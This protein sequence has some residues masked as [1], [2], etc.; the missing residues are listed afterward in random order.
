MKL[1][2]EKFGIRIAAAAAARSA[3]VALAFAVF[4]SALLGS[5]PAWS[6]SMSTSVLTFVAATTTTTT[7]GGDDVEL[8]IGLPQEHVGMSVEIELT[9]IGTALAGSDYTLV[10]ANPAQEIILGDGA[11]SPL[12]LSVESAPVE[13][14]LLLRPRVDD[15]ISQGDRFLN[16]RISRY[17][18]GLESTTT[19][20]TTT[21]TTT[22][23]STTTETTT[24]ET[25]TTETVSLPPALD[26]T[27]RDDE[28]PTV[29]QLQVGPNDDFAC[30]LLD[31]GS[32]RCGGDNTDGRATPPPDLGAVAQLGTGGEFAC[33]L[34][35]LGELR[36]WGNDV[37][38]RSL[39][40]EDALGPFIQLAVSRGHSCALAGSGQVHCWGGNGDGQ[41]K[42]TVGLGP[43]GTLGL[44]AQIGVG[45]EHSCA[46]TD[47]G[48]V[49]C[50]GKDGQSSPPDELGAVAQLGV[51]GSHNCALQRD[52]QVRCWGDNGS[53]RSTPPDDLGTVVQL[54][55]GRGHSCALTELG[56][57]RCWGA[58]ND[59][60]VSSQPNDLGPVA[61]VM[62]GRIHSC[63]RTVAGL[64]RCWGDSTEKFESL[65]MLPGSVTAID[66]S[67]LCALLADGSVYCPTKTEL[68]PPELSSSEVVMVILPQQLQ[69]GERAAIRFADL[70]ETAAAFTVRI[71]VFGEGTADVGSDYRL[72]DSNGRPVDAE[73][74]GSYL[75]GW[76][77]N[78]PQLAGNSLEAS[79]AG[80]GL[81]L[82][83]RPLESLLP[84]GS[85]SGSTPSI[86]VVAQSVELVELSDRLFF[87][88]STD[89]LSEGDEEA[90]FSIWL[91]PA[92]TGL[93]VELELLVGGTALAGSDYTLLA[94]DS[95]PGLMLGTGN[96]TI[97]LV[98]ESAFTPL[99]LRLRPRAADR[100]SQG[101]RLLNL[102]ISRYQVGLEITTT[103]TVSL[104]P[105]LDLTIVDDE[106]PTVQQLVF[107]GPFINFACILLNGGSVACE[108]IPFVPIVPRAM[109]PDDLGPVVQLGAG[110]SYACALTVFGEVRCWGGD[111]TLPADDLGP[112]T[113]L[114]VGDIHSCAVADSGQ[115]HCWGDNDDG[116]TTPTVGLG[117]GGALGPVVQLGVGDKHS[118]ALTDSGNV[119]CW[120]S[121]K[122][123]QSS[124]PDAQHPDGALGAVAQLG[125]GLS[126]NC[127]LLR[128]GQVRCWGRNA[129]GS[130]DSRARP[131]EDLGTV[132][133]LAVGNEHTCALTELGR[134]RCWGIDND[135]E[136]SPPDD[137]GP[138]AEIM[139]GRD[140]ACA[141]TVAGLLRCWGAPVDEFASLPPGLVTAID[142]SSLCALLADGSVYCPTKTELIPPELSPSEVVMSVWPQQL[143][144]GQRAAIR[145]ADLRETAAAFTVRIEVFGEGTADVGSYY[146][147]LDSNGQP[148]EAEPDA[149]SVLLT[150]NPPLAWLEATLAGS[151]SRLYVRPLN[152][153]MPLGL[154]PSVR[155]AAQPVDLVELSDRPFFAA[156]T[157]TLSEGGEEAQ[158]S[159]LLP[160]AHAGL[161]VE[162]ELLVG[163]NAL[164]G[165]DYTLVAADSTLGITI[166][167]GAATTITLVVESAPTEPLGLRLLPRADDDI[168]QGPRLLTLRISRY[169]VAAEGEV[170]EDLPAA[171]DFI[172][173]DD[174]SP[175][176]QWIQGN[177]IGN[178][179]C[180]QLNGY[181]ARC[182]GNDHYRQPPDNL[183]PVAQLEVSLYRSCAVLVSGAVS[184]W[185][186][187]HNFERIPPADLGPVAQLA[188]GYN[189][190]CAVTVSGRARCWGLN[191][192]GQATPPEELAPV[193]QVGVGVSH[194][195]ALTEA[196][197]L[198]C[199]GFDDVAQSQ[200]PENDALD[201]FVQLVVGSY[202][203]CAVTAAGK[204]SCWGENTDGRASPP[205][206]LEPI[207]QI[208][209]GFLHSCA[210]TDSGVRCW[211]FNDNNR[212]TPP[213]DLAAVA[214]LSVG[215]KH[216]CALTEMGTVH[217]WGDTRRGQAT[218]PEDLGPVV[219]LSV[220]QNHSCAL[221]V[222]GEVRCWGSNDEGQS[223]PPAGLGVVSRIS[224]V[225]LEHTC[226]AMV[227]GGVRC[228]GRDGGGRSLPP[229][230]LE[231]V[232]QLALGWS[233][234]CA[235]LTSGGV[236]C[237]GGSLP[238][239]D[240]GMV[241]EIG[242]G[243]N[244]SC[245][246]TVSGGVRCW[247]DNTDGRATPPDE[248]P[249]VVQL[250]VGFDHS[251]ALTV[252]GGVRCWGDNADGQASPPVDLGPVAQLVVG[253]DHS[254]ALTVAGRVRC[255]G[256]G[257]SAVSFPPLGAI[258]AIATYSPNSL[259]SGF[260][261]CALLAEGSVY[262]LDGAEPTPPELRPGDV[263][264]SVWPRQ[265]LRGQR[266]AIRFVDLRDT[267]GT[268]T[269]RIEVFG[270]GAADVGSHYRLLDSSGQ[271]LSAEPGANSVLL[272]GNPPM[273]WLESTSTALPLRLYVRPIELLSSA[274]QAPSI[275]QVEQPVELIDGLFFAASTDT[276]TEGGAE[277]Q[278]S[279][280]LPLAHTGLD[281][282]LE[283]T[284]TGNALA[285]AD[286][287][288]DVADSQPGI[289]L[290]GDASLIAL[291]VDLAPAEPLRLL[292]R[293]RAGDSLN[294]GDRS[295]RL[296][297]SF[298]QVISGDG[299]TADLP[300]ALDFMIRDGDDAQVVRQLLSN[301]SGS[302]NCALLNGGGVR[303][304]GNDRYAQVSPPADLGP[305]A[306]LV[307]GD[308]H[309]CAVTVS[310]LARCWGRNDK[311]QSSPPAELGPV[312]QL[313]VGES[314]SCAIT[315][316]GGVRCWGNDG[317][318][319]ASPPDDLG[320]VVQLAL[321]EYH[322]CAVTTP[323]LLV[324]CWGDDTSGQ[325]SPPDDLGP[326]LQLAV[327][328]YYSCAL[329]AASGRV[330]CWGSNEF[331]KSSPPD[332]L[333]P[334][335]QFALGED[336]GC[337]VTAAG[338]VG[339][340]GRNQYGQ[341]SPP[342]ELG[343][344]AQLALGEDHSCALL[345]DGRL[346]CWGRGSSA[347]PSPQLGAATAIAIYSPKSLYSGY[348]ACKILAEGSLYC[349]DQ[350]ERIPSELRPGEVVMSVWPQ[351]LETGQRA[352]IRFADL[353]EMTAAFTARI[354]VFGDGS[355][356][357]GSNYRLLDGDGTTPLDAEPD[358]SYLIEGGAD[359]P[360]LAENPP[361]AWLESLAGD[362]SL[363]LYVRP[364]EL[365]PVSGP[366]PTIRVV[367]QS[368]ELVAEVLGSLTVAG[369]AGLQQQTVPDESVPFELTVT[370]EGSK[371]TA[372]WQ[373][374]EALRLQ[375][376]ASAPGVTVVY[377]SALSFNGGVATVMVSVTPSP[378][379]DAMVTFHV[380]GGPGA[381]AAV[382]ANMVTVAV[383]AAEIL[384]SL[385]V[386]GP[387]AL[388]QQTGPDEPVP[389]ELTVTA[390]GNKGTAPWQPTEVLR[391]QHTAS[392]PGVTV[393]YDSALSFSDGV[394]T[395]MVSVT[396]SPGTDAMLTFSVAG[397]PGALA[398][399]VAN[400]VTVDVGV[401]EALS[402]VTLT[403]QGELMRTVQSGQQEVLIAVE[404]M[405]A[406]IVADEPEQTQLRLRAMVTNGAEVSGP[407]D[408]VVPA[409][410]SATANLSLMLGDARQTT[411]SFAVVG[412]PSGATLNS[413]EV[414]VV[415]V[416]VPVSLVL[417][418]TPALIDDLAPRGEAVTESRV[419][420]EIQG[421]DG[422]PF[423][424]LSLE[425]NTIVTEVTD[426][427]DGVAG[428]IVLSFGPLAQTE[429]GVYDSILRVTVAA[430]RVSAANVRL[431]V[432]NTPITALIQLAR[433][434]IVDSLELSLAD[435]ALE[436]SAA[437]VSVQTTATVT[438]MNQFGQ[439]FSPTGL[440]LRVV[441]TATESEVLVT[442]PALV[443]NAE[444]VAQSVLELTP[445]GRDRELRV[446]VIGVAAPGVTGNTE[447]LTLTA[448]E[449]L[450]QVILTVL[451]GSKQFVSSTTFAISLE[452]KLVRAGDRPLTAATA[453]TVQLQVSIM[454]GT[455]LS[456]ASFSVSASGEDPSS[457][458][459]DAMFSG[460]ASLVTIMLSIV[461]G[462][463]ADSSMAILPT[464]IVRVR[465]PADL[466]VDENAVFDVR[467][468]VLL[469][470]A[471]EMSLPDST[472]E[473]VKVQLGELLNPSS[474][475]IRLDVDG[476]NLV[477]PIDM[478]V[479][480]RYLAGLRGD[481]LI[482][483]AV[484]TEASERRARE[485]IE[486]S[487]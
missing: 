251:C 349:L 28:L 166:G 229:A 56:Q 165:A 286:Y 476:N 201:P 348:G 277:A 386:A 339:C 423:V 468:A 186:S 5:A 267:T 144:P 35:I 409:G 300:P 9:V 443:F 224:S 196:G 262:C 310:G 94:A 428:D 97:T 46:L 204:V 440:R 398:A 150:G 187:M 1:A 191:N 98:V 335:V 363:R 350:P 459:I 73:P 400:M 128:D 431:T 389:F 441:D 88:A 6:Q 149:N 396:P 145:F 384:G 368:V 418:A 325:S 358:G 312:A 478:R 61:E 84:L 36:C 340:W 221:T 178:T 176:V 282:E 67:S 112:F 122:Y 15:R 151:G 380:A 313:A 450:G 164:A 109:P 242:V 327:G 146:R 278:L 194:S 233:Q 235:L 206:D 80:R 453:L 179:V 215:Q 101:D 395:V 321:S 362:R 132:V 454:G 247:G 17:Q 220:G 217:C 106:P 281:V 266:A 197:R 79:L 406:Y 31:G 304:W 357:V 430:G 190:S 408:V 236:R 58:D 74:D 184:C 291:R 329:S 436:Q 160:L 296:Q 367:A 199:W 38:D 34:T 360:Q 410:G 19:E 356:E 171:L 486:P 126:H 10:D 372:S 230:D 60:E 393:D 119:H 173:L 447:M 37:D 118:C 264:M 413:Q 341:S 318:G 253:F 240:L 63:V 219:Q 324:R 42:P 373:P 299:G 405:T 192:H 227:L 465:L 104:P 337:A 461:G 469:L 208:G 315:T 271:P 44:V 397:E 129:N 24:T 45:D 338:E 66:F 239:Q 466:D 141:R 91:P 39:P 54:A 484:D 330:S 137:L 383:G 172:I 382:A 370:A 52:G 205:E 130:G 359:F 48:Q 138:V 365:L 274:G 3:G 255:W 305:V 32:V 388:Q 77:P 426:V 317:A 275:R 265:L 369:P 458:E 193:A 434:V 467:D 157:D 89:T 258:A 252:A 68:I 182:W 174:E 123:G 342:A 420:A 237:W 245:A 411:V 472:P 345:T 394:A 336:H 462:V 162:L 189:H 75:L 487:R 288:L 442:T 12:T 422:R 268:F 33:A 366:T 482:G 27:I 26:L 232:A 427:V 322:S 55:V 121:D 155:Q 95:P 211:G 188:G 285:G 113:Q 85:T 257:A 301:R 249:S 223:T 326:V 8:R 185:D 435:V 485:I 238:P 14:R 284:V 294:Q 152:P 25:T 195:C 361:A 183:G 314:H 148:L 167:G 297:I 136:A 293:A 222:S 168:S 225:G 62:A 16:L 332:A 163:G 158:L 92:H 378:G 347:V 419:R 445:R 351:R 390:V 107:G 115:V 209:V 424:G 57:V 64:L 207:T 143:Q 260:G 379:T 111:F 120:G 41:S 306:Q 134:V 331:A 334:V 256:R 287:T 159:I 270:E 161:R 49:H 276:L 401:A 292:L 246:L 355:A 18:V 180:A 354:E 93:R 100:L 114:A 387:A 438:V 433:S 391:L 110:Y 117:Q 307:V 218:P 273:A 353:R 59:G 279:I 456:P 352:A 131:P 243:Q 23:E 102:R 392:G 96:S 2:S 483:G 20:S 40:P 448:V 103:E 475:D 308:F 65:F 43:G 451:G 481:S 116:Q 13:L 269:A 21:E 175:T 399:V 30:A 142:S 417:S 181:S 135:G 407:V 83:V 437:G 69:P 319:W 364:L 200:P 404:L 402:E 311:G 272:T 72:L 140:H 343:A 412:L 464:N 385:T 29:Q 316:S 254:C 303:C 226:A 241:E 90:Q 463:P 76:D 71:E 177:E 323:E 470:K 381:L 248:L 87:T 439:P 4:A 471:A 455:L 446:D 82:Y 289:A 320:S 47:S 414:Q 333:G 105:A 295:L 263:V 479:L 280:W 170:T 432:P 86:R 231:P 11:D 415:L 139:V 403:V 444:G 99:G 127:A 198:H 477:E 154:A 371:G 214:Q 228:W 78:S 377:D 376:A 133:Q 156:S 283:L 375:F 374:T 473:R 480:L 302:V 298:Y 416:P 452:L 474:P 153:L 53:N 449:A 50:W 234:S 259:Y 346:R 309:S 169:Q 70:R 290:G 261:S 124:P 213:D 212:A 7:E 51:G 203:S 22:T 202:H 457:V 328:W 250:A 460:N 425:T 344:V 216:S 108:V 429:A 244:H 421:S 81:R 210:L 147:L 125:V